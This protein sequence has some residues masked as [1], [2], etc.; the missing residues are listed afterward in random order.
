MS[1]LNISYEM[2][3]I[4]TSFFLAV[5]ILPPVVRVAKKIKLFDRQTG[6]KIHKSK[7]PPVGGVAFCTA[8]SLAFLLNSENFD[9]D[10]KK[11]VFAASFFLFFI[12]LL[13]D[14][15][16]IPAKKKFAIEAIIFSILIVLGNYRITSFDGLLGIGEVGYLPGF[17]ITLVFILGTVNAWNLIDGIDGQ[18]SGLGI[19]ASLFF[20]IWFSAAG[21]PTLAILA[22]SL[23]GSLAGFFLFNVYGKKF[24][25]FMGD[26]GSLVIGL[27]LS[28]LA[29]RFMNLSSGTAGTIH[30]NSPPAVAFAVLFIPLFDMVR[31][32]V[33]RILKGTTPFFGDRNHLHHKLLKFFPRHIQVTGMTIGWNLLL[34]I[35]AVLLDHGG[36]NIHLLFG[37]L[38]VAGLVIST[39]N[40]GYLIQFLKNTF[41]FL[42]KSKVVFRHF[43]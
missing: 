41:D 8:A 42:S 12:G 23:S 25:V 19:Q 22:F 16:D 29:I 11:Y 39:L 20:G 32:I 1:Y 3:V 30:F 21:H 40:W 4:G 38:V 5:L 2:I 24:K 6:R 28:V 31:V 27:I 26:S 18:A 17:I 15:I 33:V 43:L 37:I 35:L 10:S 14:I 36:V 34:I 13:D 9:I 7:I